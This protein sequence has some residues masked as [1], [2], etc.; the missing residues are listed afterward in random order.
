M[1]ARIRRRLKIK[2]FSPHRLRHSLC[3]ELYHNGANKVLIST[4]LGHSNVN[5]TK[6]YVHPDLK[7]NL[8]M[9]DKYHKA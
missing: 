6:R 9:F 1:F 3:S 2:N 4:I 7:R 5:T 8:K